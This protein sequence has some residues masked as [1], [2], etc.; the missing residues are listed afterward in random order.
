[1]VEVAGCIIRDKKGRILLLHRQT[2][3]LQQ[4]ETPGGKVEPGESHQ[5]AA[6]REVYEELGVQVEIVNRLGDA[7]FT[8]GK[9]T[10]LYTWFEAI[11]TTN[12]TPHVSEPDKFDDVRF[13]DIPEL[14]RRDD[15]SP[16]VI[17]LL[18]SGVL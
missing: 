11:T 13:W 9:N 2:E 4:W 1:M 7:S 12:D 15:L 10:W 16:N 3:E 17:N 18:R 8:N 5:D 14:G 6:V